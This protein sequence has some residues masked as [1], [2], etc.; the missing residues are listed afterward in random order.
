MPGRWVC[1]FGPCH[2]CSTRPGPVLLEFISAWTRNR[3]SHPKSQTDTHLPPSAD[4]SRAPLSPYPL[5]WPRLVHTAAPPSRLIAL[6]CLQQESCPVSLVRTST[7][8]SPLSTFLPRTLHPPLPGETCRSGEAA[9]DPTV[10]DHKLV[11]VLTSA[12]ASLPPPCAWNRPLSG[13]GHS[14][15]VISV[16]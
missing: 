11:L 14:C 6:P 15:T 3:A 4:F 8:M 10:A 13:P 9:A 16:Q 7:P 1:A 12:G 5:P 2:V